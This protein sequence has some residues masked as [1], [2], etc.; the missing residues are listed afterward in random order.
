MIKFLILDVFFP[1]SDF[2]LAA[3]ENLESQE[4][5]ALEKQGIQACDQ[6]FI[7]DYIVFTTLLIK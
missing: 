4:D 5:V 6:L 1:I 2:R 3:D 7:D